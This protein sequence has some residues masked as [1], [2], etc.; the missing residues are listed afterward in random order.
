MRFVT[1][2]IALSRTVRLTREFHEIQ[3]IADK[4]SGTN[5]RNLALLTLRETARAGRCE[6]PHLYGTPADQRYT[7]WG[8]GTQ[9]GIVRAR[10]DNMQVRLHGIALWLAVAYYETRDTGIPQVAGIH[11]HILGLLKQL[12]QNVPNELA[13]AAKQTTNEAVA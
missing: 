7:L 5:T 13:D 12:K 10:S 3:Q 11:R 6:F 1:R 2:I 4:L 9:T 8:S